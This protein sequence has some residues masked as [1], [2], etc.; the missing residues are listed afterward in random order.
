VLTIFLAGWRSE[1]ESPWFY[2]GTTAELFRTV[3]VIGEQVVFVEV[4]PGH[5]INVAHI[6]R[7]AEDAEQPDELDAA[8]A[9][10]VAQRLAEQP[11]P[12]TEWVGGVEPAP[13]SGCGGKHVGE[14][15]LV[16]SLPGEVRTTPI[17]GGPKSCRHG[18]IEGTCSQC[19]GSPPD[20]EAWQTRNQP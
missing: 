14:C 9:E 18:F 20:V 6:E 2:E 8:A 10:R 3:R 4:S 15:G 5:L 13:C 17:P 12:N 7:I 19:T 1:E 16:A 11:T